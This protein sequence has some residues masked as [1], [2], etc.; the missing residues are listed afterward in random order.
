MLIVQRSDHVH[1]ICIPFIINSC[2]H[3]SVENASLSAECRFNVYLQKF[4]DMVA[5]FHPNHLLTFYD[6]LL[7]LKFHK[8]SPL[9]KCQGDNVPVESAHS[10]IPGIDVNLFP[11]RVDGDIHVLTYW[12]MLIYPLSLCQYVKHVYHQLFIRS[13]QVFAMIWLSAGHL[14]W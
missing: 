4:T 14:S 2:H 11:C 1:K 5:K 9:R 8:F 6:M 13:E 7:P 10:F 3:H 12:I